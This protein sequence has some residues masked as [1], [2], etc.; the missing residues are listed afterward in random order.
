MTIKGAIFDMDGTLIDSL[1]FWDQYWEK[2]GQIFL[3]TEDFRPAK[4]I[5]QKLRTMIFSDGMIYAN[6]ACGLHLNEVALIRF[7]EEFI[8]EYYKNHARPKTGVIELLDHL[9][10]KNVKMC[11]ASAT[12]LR[13]VQLA[14]EYC[15]LSRYF[16]GVISCE[17][18]GKGKDHPDVYLKALE[19]LGT[20]VEDTWIFEDSFVALETAKALGVHTVGVYDR[21]NYGQD[22]LRA[23]AEIY[24]G[25]GESM[26]EVFSKQE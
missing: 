4:E 19:I 3:G 25:E 16:Q 1:N 10:H 17:D 18:V 20:S 2:L 11:V 9:T 14:L 26:G 6:E 24:L 21:Y 5:D 8:E 13:Y 12:S 7:S 22:R 23:A 15:G